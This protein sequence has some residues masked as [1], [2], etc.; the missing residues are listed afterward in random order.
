MSMKYLGETFDLHGGGMDLIF[1]HH[2]NEIAQSRAAGAGFARYWLHNAVLGIAGEKMSKSLGNSLRVDEML[3]TVRPAELRYYLAQAHYRSMQEY[4][5]EALGEA[6]AAYGRIEGFVQRATETLAAVGQTNGTSNHL[7]EAATLADS[8]QGSA[9]APVRATGVPLSF[10]SAM[11]DDFGVPAALAAVHAAVRDGNSALQAGRLAEV[12]ESLHDVRTMMGVL[13]LDPLS[14]PWNTGQAGDERVRDVVQA[15][16]GVTL[17]Q[18]DAARARKDY[19]TADALRDG[20]EKAGIQIED[21]PAGPR[22]K[23]R[24]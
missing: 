17:E 18:R 1:P 14:P 2:E 4:S 6:V 23:L 22:W 7:N 11:D 21:T 9:G 19:A 10:A 16:V 24:R 8:A 5:E 3:A 13:G 15:L 12:R 20:L